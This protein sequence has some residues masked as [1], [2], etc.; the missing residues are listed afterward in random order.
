MTAR[1]P[2]VGGPVLTYGG[3]GYA[4]LLVVGETVLEP[5]GLVAGFH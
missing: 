2:V 1:F 5:V 4:D 3:C